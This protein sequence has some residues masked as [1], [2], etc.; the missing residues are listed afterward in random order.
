MYIGLAFSLKLFSPHVNK[1]RLAYWMVKG[2]V[3]Q[4]SQLTTHAWVSSGKTRR[5]V[6]L[7]PAPNYW[8]PEPE[9]K[10][11]VVL[12]HYVLRWH[13]T[14]QQKLTDTSRYDVMGG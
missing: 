12:G 8:T 11:M 3:G 10:E 6:L 5:A 1:L 9:I 4:L 7:S 14:T 13:V 2:H